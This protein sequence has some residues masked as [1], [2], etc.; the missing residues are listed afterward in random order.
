VRDADPTR[1]PTAARPGYVSEAE[2]RPPRVGVARRFP[3]GQVEQ[4]AVLA[5]RGVGRR[6]GDSLANR[7]AFRNL[8][9][10]VNRDINFAAQALYPTPLPVKRIRDIVEPPITSHPKR[11]R[12]DAQHEGGGGG[13]LDDAA[14]HDAPHPTARPGMSSSGGRRA[15]V[16]PHDSEGA[17]SSK[18]YDAGRFGASARQMRTDQNSSWALMSR[19]SGFLAALLCGVSALGCDA[20]Y[21]TY[22]PVQF[23]VMDIE[24]DAPAVGAIVRVADVAGKHPDETPEHYVDRMSR[25]L[26]RATTDAHGT[27]GLRVNTTMLKGG[28]SGLLFDRRR[29]LDDRVTGA[30]YF[31]E[32]SATGA[33]EILTMKMKVGVPATGSHYSVIVREIGKAAYQDSR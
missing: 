5:V 12:G 18:R 13:E 24:R 8:V 20:I 19:R 15:Q 30:T 16:V 26:N 7:Q 27:A 17:H 29:P 4:C 10:P 21:T 28:L 1:E 31:V 23:Q 33:G 25:G 14:L 2:E 3:I 9:K 32:V 11:H 6:V 22:Q